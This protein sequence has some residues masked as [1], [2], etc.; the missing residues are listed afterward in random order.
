M[1]KKA[2]IVKMKRQERLV[3]QY[4]AKR[5]K[6]KMQ[7]DYQAWAKLPADSSP[8]RLHRRD[9]LDGRPHG[10]LRKFKLARIKSRRLALKGQIPG[11]KK[12][13]W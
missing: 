8:V 9:L 11:I 10:Y 1:A 6:L 13:S 4:A 2:K 3:A 5:K 7:G 12:A